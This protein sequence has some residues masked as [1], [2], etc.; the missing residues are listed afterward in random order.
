M[1]YYYTE[2]QELK[3]FFLI[4]L[5]RRYLRDHGFGPRFFKTKGGLFEEV[6]SLIKIVFPCLTWEIK[7]Q[8]DEIME[9]KIFDGSLAFIYRQKKYH[10]RAEKLI[11]IIKDPPDD[12]YSELCYFDTFELTP[13]GANFSLVVQGDD[14][15]WRFVEGLIKLKKYALECCP[16]IT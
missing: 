7:G 12:Y 8:Y 3:L 5:A 14:L 11:K 10:R 9:G 4:L 13:H 2:F 15:P 16:L 1:A 6:A